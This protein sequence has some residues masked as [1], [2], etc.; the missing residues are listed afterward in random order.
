MPSMNRVRRKSRIGRSVCQWTTGLLLL[1]SEADAQPAFQS[2]GFLPGGAYS[3]AGAVSDDGLVVVGAA[4]GPVGREGFVWTPS[5]GM[6]SV[7]DLPGGDFWSWASGISAD[8]QTVVGGSLSSLGNEAFSWS[9]GSIA[10]L[11]DLPGG[12]FGSWAFGATSDASTIV[13][14]GAGREGS[15]AVCWTSGG[16]RSLV[17]AGQPVHPSIANAVT[18]DG[19]VIVGLS[20]ES[21][22]N[23]QAFRWE[24]GSLIG[25][26]DLPG[27]PFQS[28]AVDVS[29]DGRVV[30]GLGWAD[31]GVA[32]A[33]YATRWTDATGMVSLGELPGGGYASSASAVTADGFRV[34]GASLSD[35]GQEGFI[36]DPIHGM[37][38]LTHVLRDVYGLNMTGWKIRGCWGVSPD[39]TV[40]VGVS[41]NPQQQLEAFRAVI[42]PFCY[43][44]CDG[45][46]G[47]GGVPILTVA[48]FACFQTKFVQGNLLYC[49]CNMDDRL[50]V[51][52]FGCFQTKFVVGCP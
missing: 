14:V 30:V 46:E 51:A 5:G 34:F 49:D 20:W 15:E 18:S 31:V 17:E 16:I 3:E 19:A 8:G 50:T 37:R 25:L 28:N 11:G 42:R 26:G 12:A 24:N 7:G 2:L 52:D 1:G 39:G 22:E 33:S 48:D 6:R 44:N 45:S 21:A 35:L 29:G 32:I 41:V 13:G 43:A 10:G 36:W 9:S 47:S 38:T 27:G 40:V 4:F 23:H